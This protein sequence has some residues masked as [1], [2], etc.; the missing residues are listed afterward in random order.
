[1]QYRIEAWEVV[2][3]SVRAYGTFWKH[4]EQGPA[5]FIKKVGLGFS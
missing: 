3:E 1:M 4:R 2:E 5:L